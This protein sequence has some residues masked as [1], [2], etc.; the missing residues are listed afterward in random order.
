MIV[1]EMSP[2]VM[3][4]ICIAARYSLSGDLTGLK[5]RGTVRAFLHTVESFL[6]ENTDNHSD[7]RLQV[8]LSLKGD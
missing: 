8:S 7:C 1:V 4:E 6:A 5:C 2:E 3:K